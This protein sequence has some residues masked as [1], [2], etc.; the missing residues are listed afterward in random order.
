MGGG[1]GGGGGG[2]VMFK[3]NRRKI[4]RRTLSL[5]VDGHNATYNTVTA[6]H[7]K[8]NKVLDIKIVHVK[9]RS[10]SLVFLKP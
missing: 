8:T 6:L 1:G 5:A 4:K 2:G 9:V 3:I 7:V 10:T